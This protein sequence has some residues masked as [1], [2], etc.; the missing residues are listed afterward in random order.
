MKRWDKADIPVATLH[1][2]KAMAVAEENYMEWIVAADTVVVHNNKILGKSNSKR[3][4]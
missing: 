3:Q 1:A 2:E 4:I